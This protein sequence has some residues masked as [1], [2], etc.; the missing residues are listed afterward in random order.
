STRTT[1]STE[2]LGSVMLL[3]GS[4]APCLSR[5]CCCLDRPAAAEDEQLGGP[6]RHEEQDA[7]EGRYEDRSPEL[8]RKR[9]VLLVEVHDCP[10]ETLRKRRRALTDDRPDHA[11][12][13]RDLQRG[14]QI[15]QA[16]W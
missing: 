8:A 4:F 7:D 10:P 15:G 11:G 2:P 5:S 3:P 14:E 1:S 12:R 9:D 16:R 6:D 13:R